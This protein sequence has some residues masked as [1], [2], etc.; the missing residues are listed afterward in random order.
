[1]RAISELNEAS[2]ATLFDQVLTGS[3]VALP[4]DLDRSA[5]IDSPSGSGI[6]VPGCVFWEA[7]ALGIVAAEVE[8]KGLFQVCGVGSWNAERSSRSTTESVK[9]RWIASGRSV[10]E[11]R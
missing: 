10:S 11:S 3:E 6:A 2:L 5:R 1:M 8:P 9:C 4:I 7:A